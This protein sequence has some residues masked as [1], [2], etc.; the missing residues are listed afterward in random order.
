MAKRTLTSFLPK[1]E[2]LTPVQIA[3]PE[4]LHQR[5]RD[6][7]EQDRKNGLKIGWREVIQAACEAYLFERANKG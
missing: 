6:Q 5:V 2:K 7:I 3:L 4:D 1:K